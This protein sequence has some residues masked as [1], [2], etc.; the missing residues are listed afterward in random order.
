M[1]GLFSPIDSSMSGI[2]SIILKN[3]Q[4]PSSI[5]KRTTPT[6]FEL[7]A[8]GT[9]LVASAPQEGEWQILSLD[10]RRLVPQAFGKTISVR[11][12]ALGSQ[13]ALVVFREPGKAPVVRRWVSR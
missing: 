2:I 10:G 4:V 5:A 13:V 6:G 12:E 7:R 11:L 3:V 8:S 1:T 9:M